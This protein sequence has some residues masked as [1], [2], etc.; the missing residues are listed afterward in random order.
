[1]EPTHD[2]IRLAVPYFAEGREHSGVG[3]EVVEIVAID[4]LDPEPVAIG[5]SRI[6]HTDRHSVEFR[7]SAQKQH[8]PDSSLARSVQAVQSSRK[9]LQATLANGFE[10][11]LLLRR[12]GG[13]R[14]RIG[15]RS[16]RGAF[17]GC[18]GRPLGR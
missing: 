1:A 17:R 11:D 5:R 9:L 13:S 7:G 14:R 15:R 18:G 16:S 6:T 4:A 2:L 3:S 8:G 12:R 10:S